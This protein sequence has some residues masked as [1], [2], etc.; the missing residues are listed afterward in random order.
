MCTDVA[1]RSS[2][3]ATPWRPARA[4]FPLRALDVDETTSEYPQF[5]G[6]ECWN[7]VQTQGKGCRKTEPFPRRVRHL[8]RKLND[9]AQ[10]ARTRS[11]R[12]TFSN[13][14]DLREL[15]KAAGYPL[16]PLIDYASPPHGDIRRCGA[17]EK[18]W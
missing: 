5:A 11:V 3:R 14:A 4:R 8:Q 7:F 1:V 6:R 9:S 2:P 12:R 17:R 18:L 10:F 15:R 16:F 13:S